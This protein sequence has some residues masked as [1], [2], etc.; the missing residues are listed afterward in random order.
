MNLSYISI[1]TSDLDRLKNF[2]IAALGLVEFVDWS[3][4]GFRA[5]DVGGGTVMALH[6]PEAYAGLGLA[7]PAA[8]QVASLITFDPGSGAELH[9]LHNELVAQGVPVVREP[10]ETAYGSLQGIYTDV[11]GNP[12]RLNT[13]NI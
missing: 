7:V 3:H 9:G 4:D 1:V 6:S 11:D 5:I 10:F 8:G 2:Y 12:F 13:F